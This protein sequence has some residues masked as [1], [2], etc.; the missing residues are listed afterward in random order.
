MAKVRWYGTPAEQKVAQEL[1]KTSCRKTREDMEQYMNIDVDD[2][3]MQQATQ[4]DIE[5]ILDKR[6]IEYRDSLSRIYAL[7]DEKRGSERR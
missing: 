1:H 3:I 6:S 4:K 2:A 5:E 7:M